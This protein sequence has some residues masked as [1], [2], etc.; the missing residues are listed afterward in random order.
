MPNQLKPGLLNSSVT[1]CFGCFQVVYLLPS[2]LGTAFLRQFILNYSDTNSKA[3]DFLQEFKVR[4]SRPPNTSKAHPSMPNAFL[5][6][7]Y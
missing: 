3:P 4:S 6:L 5:S 1:F 2:D 7:S